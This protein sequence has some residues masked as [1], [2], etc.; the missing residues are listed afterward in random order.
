VARSRVLPGPVVPGFQ[1]FRDIFDSMGYSE[2]LPRKRGVGEEKGEGEGKDETRHTQHLSPSPMPANDH[3][4]AL[5]S[6]MVPG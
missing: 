4:R 6:L 1:N 3:T 2:V 5:E